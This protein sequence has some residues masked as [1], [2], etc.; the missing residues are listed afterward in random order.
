MEF[1]RQETD[2]RL[3][4]MGVVC[5]EGPGLAGWRMV[6]KLEGRQEGSEEVWEEEE[7][8]C[9]S[10]PAVLGGFGTRGVPAE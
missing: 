8:G 5:G 7:G 1:G 2:R 10:Q 3:G 4:G 9:R 6:G